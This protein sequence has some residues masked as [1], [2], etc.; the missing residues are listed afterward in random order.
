MARRARSAGWTAVEWTPFDWY[1]EPRWYDA[2]Y[3]RGTRGEADFLEA[4]VRR[5]GRGTPRRPFGARRALEPACGSGR[6]VAELARRGW[7]VS[8]FD[9][10]APMLEQARARL[11]RRGLEARLVRA[12]FERMPALGSFE[13]A[14]CLVSSFKYVRSDRAALAHLRSVARALVPG[15]LYVLGVDLAEYDSRER[16]VERWRGRSGRARVALE[17]VGAP[18]DPRTRS[19]AMRSR[20]V[21]RRPGQPALRRETRWSFRTYDRDELAAL[22]ARVRELEHVATHG[23]DHDPRRAI[24]FDGAQLDNV[25]VLRRRG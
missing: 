11:A 25:L 2:I 6:L 16:W 4:L 23:Y 7:R 17:V 12:R 5:H 3:A 22:V 10:S 19:E 14:Y 24:E 8:G 20:L 21:V 1:G 9:A 15:G 18:P 13:L